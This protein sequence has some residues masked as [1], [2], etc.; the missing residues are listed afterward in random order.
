MDNR[1]EP[2]FYV[3]LKGYLA[4]SLSPTDL[5]IFLELAGRPENILLLQQSF[6]NDLKNDAIDLSNP[7]QAS[8]AWSLLQAKL[9]PDRHRIRRRRFT[10]LAA[11]WRPSVFWV[12]RII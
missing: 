9:D 3:L 4:E 2:D 10:G 1:E 7:G 12:Q 5:E 6:E 8:N 11:Q